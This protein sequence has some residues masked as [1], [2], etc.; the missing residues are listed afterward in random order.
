MIGMHPCPRSK[1][2]STIAMKLS[3]GV[4]PCRNVI[5]SYALKKMLMLFPQKC[6]HAKPNYARNEYKHIDV[7]VEAVDP[8]H[9]Y[10]RV[11]KHSHHA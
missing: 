11:L 8:I 9:H 1:T 4:T 5:A 10:T 2:V 7:S 6:M 3:A